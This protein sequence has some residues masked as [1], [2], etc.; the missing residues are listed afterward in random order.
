MR[1]KKKAEKKPKVIVEEIV[2]V[3]EI[4]MTKPLEGIDLYKALKEAGFL[5]GGQGTWFI[6]PI[7]DK[8]YY[9]PTPDELYA[10]F[11][12]DPEQWNSLRDALCRAWIANRQK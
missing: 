2:V 5:Q 4:P 9:M 10:S 1:T 7:T 6:D 8:K 12:G 11:I 3:Q